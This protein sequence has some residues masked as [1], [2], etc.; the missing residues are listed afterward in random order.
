MKIIHCTALAALFAAVP[1]SA[2]TNPIPF[3][4]INL[5][6]LFVGEGVTV[7]DF[8]KDGKLDV[9]AG[10]NL[11]Y[12][13]DFTQKVKYG[14][15]TESFDGATKY[16]VYYFGLPAQDLNKDGWMD[17][18]VSG[19]V[20]ARNFWLENPKGGTGTWVEHPMVPGAGFESNGLW[21]LLKNGSLQLLYTPAD[22]SVGYGTPDPADPNKVWTYHRIGNP[23]PPGGYQGYQINTHGLGM[24]DINGDG[25]NDV[26]VPDAWFE[27]PASLVGDPLWIRHNYDFSTTNWW[28]GSQM[29]AE[30]MD[31][32]GD[33]DVVASLNGH[34]WGLAW[35][36]QVKTPAGA[37]TFNVHRIMGD[38]T[39][40]ATYGVAFSQLHSLEFADLNGDGMKDIITGKR[41]WAHGPSGDPEPMGAAVVYAFIQTRGA[42]PG[43]T[44]F[45]P[46][47]IDSSAGSG[48]RLEAIDIN[49]DGYNDVAVSS[50]KGTNVF[51]SVNRTP[52]TVLGLPPG[53]LEHRRGWKLSVRANRT[54]GLVATGEAYKALNLLG[55]SLPTLEASP[56]GVY[57]LRR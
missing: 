22:K 56:S 9:A 16:A 40:E 6:N 47:L 1:G 23:S 48:C 31:G 2:Q 17:I 38:R 14:I 52:I 29:F 15:G 11:W 7:G 19:G 25:R 46:V 41:Y 8:N 53:A 32:D 26:L 35:F 39:Q 50:K 13:P 27:Q 24:G 36:E 10:V 57:I 5:T 45:K 3:K 51:L 42:G 49:G 33:A 30:D 34:G 55:A 54:P 12:G 37:I 43:L 4:K 18:P 21:P 20:G 44:T 28:G